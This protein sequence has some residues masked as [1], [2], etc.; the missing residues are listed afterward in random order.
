MKTTLVRL[1]SI[2]LA[3]VGLTFAAEAGEVLDRVMAKKTLVNA[4]EGE[5]PPFNSIGENN[6][7]VGFDIDVAK[8]VAKRMGVELQ[9]ITRGWD[10]ITAGR[11]ANRWDIA[12]SSM[13][14]TKTRQEVLDFPAR[15]YF[16]PG[17]ILVHKDNTSINKVSDLS[18]KRVGVQV[19]TTNEKFLQK[20]L[21][22]SDTPL[23]YDFDNVKIVSYETE[24]P[25]IDDLALG[26]GVRLD[27]MCLG[28]L[29]AQEYIKSGKP[30]KIVGEPLFHE[31]ASIAIDKGDPELGARIAEIVEAMRADGTLKRL[32]EERFGID[33][34]VPPATN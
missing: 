22:L 27:A 19:A 26:D 24:P 12:I 18:G 16:T 28:P 9:N 13:A 32:S 23:N 21:Q 15:Y 4:V 20:N 14:N 25:A 29:T 1:T 33:I 7:I 17:I 8:E 11:W 5:Y 6:E 31:E 10:V 2:L 34:T 30:L 3:V